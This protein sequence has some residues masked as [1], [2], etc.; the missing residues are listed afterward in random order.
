MKFADKLTILRRNRGYSQEAL[1]EKLGVSRQAVSKWEN[2]QSEPEIA[3]LL[4]ISRLFQVTVDYL[5]RE[6]SDC[7]KQPDSLRTVATM[8]KKQ[9]LDFLARA[10]RETYAGYGEE[11]EPSRPASHDY[12]YQEGQWLYIDTWLGG[13]RFAG[14]EAVWQ[15]GNALYTMNYCGRVLGDSFSGDFLKAALRAAP[16]EC[17]FRGPACYEDGDNRYE[18]SIDGSLAW[19]QGY[20]EIR[21][22]GEKVYECFFHGG[23]IG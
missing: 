2:D 16:Q 23:L 13:E 9:L 3:S 21:W 5:I 12:R 20:E 1:A 19:F 14:Q 4:A 10:S 18:C 7:M 15:E 8:E 11:V 17:P 22:Q 6:D